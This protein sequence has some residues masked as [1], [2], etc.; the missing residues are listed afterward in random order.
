M[1]YAAT[2]ARV[3]NG[4]GLRATSYTDLVP[5]RPAYA[6]PIP[7]SQPSA[8]TMSSTRSLASPKSMRELSLKNS[9]FCTPA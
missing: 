2:R 3:G 9:G 5:Q 6:A 7:G 1:S 4:T 8:R